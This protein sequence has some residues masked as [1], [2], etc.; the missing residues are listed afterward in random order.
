MK[1]KILKDHKKRGNKFIHPLSEMADSNH[2]WVNDTLPELIFVSELMN[3]CGQI[4]GVQ[5]AIEFSETIAKFV[6]GDARHYVC[7]T[8]FVNNLSEEQKKSLLSELDKKGILG[9]LQLN[10]IDF[11]RLY[12]E[13]PLNFLLEGTKLDANLVDP[14][15]LSLYK[16]SLLELLDKTSKR[17]T[18]C[19]GFIIA[20]YIKNRL[21]SMPRELFERSM[22]VNELINYPDTLKSRVVASSCRASSVMFMSRFIN[23]TE[24]KRWAKQFWQKGLIIENLEYGS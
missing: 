23:T 24:T 2:N 3:G 20:Y 1:K 21:I 18:L 13:C 10:L 22:D 11:I 12:Q 4:K 6:E 15:Y 9:K 19:I 16:E 5:L 14:T 8:S 17:S 7:F